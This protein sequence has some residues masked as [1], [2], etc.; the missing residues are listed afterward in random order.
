MA[1][2]V[3]LTVTR[4]IDPKTKA[5]V[6]ARTPGAKKVK[7]KTDCYYI[8]EKANGRVRR[9]NTNCTDLEAARAAYHKFRVNQ[10]RGEH[11]LLDPFKPHLDRPVKAHLAEYIVALKESSRYAPYPRTVDRELTK[12]F[13]GAG[14]DQLRDMTADR[15]Q[16]YLSSLTVKAATKNKLRTYLMSFAGWL[17]DRDRMSR[18][19][20]EKVK[21]AAPKPEEG[22]K[23]RR[24]ALDVDALC[25]LL[26][27][28]ERYPLHA[29]LT[30]KGG[31]PRKD[32]AKIRHRNPVALSPETIAHLE[33]QGKGR[34]LL[35]RT[36]LLTGLRRG[37]LARLQ[38]RHFRVSDGIFD[39]PGRLTKNG[40]A[41]KLP[42]VPTL[43]ADLRQWAVTTERGPQSPLFDVPEARNMVRQHKARL[44]L[45]GIK[46]E[47]QH[48]FADFHSLR[49]AVNTYLRGEKVELRIRQ[50]FLRHAATDLTT[51]AYDDERGRDLEP[52]LKLLVQLDGH[53]TNGGSS[54]HEKQA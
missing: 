40:R 52:L 11:G 27:A 25:A 36:A 2:L 50:R 17:T 35:Y 44:K 16:V 29:A 15:I 39:I 26:A 31:R 3:K 32:G 33:T 23:R 1:A 14:I 12:L 24:R 47:T 6:P 20:V 38:L 48:G 5:R 43:A 49:K 21:R 4:W 28:V 10:E 9:T 19:P 13:R 42:I 7:D 46:Y 41:A 37:E 30:P 54:Q 34:S 45:A 22:E 53:L 8:V 51:T 18:N